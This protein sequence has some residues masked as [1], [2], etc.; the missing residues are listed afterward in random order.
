L[1]FNCPNPGNYFFLVAIPM[2]TETIFSCHSWEDNS[3][4]FLKFLL[5]SWRIKIDTDV[6]LDAKSAHLIHF[7]NLVLF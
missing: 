7:H 2:M 3:V 1:V 6:M 4:E 5:R